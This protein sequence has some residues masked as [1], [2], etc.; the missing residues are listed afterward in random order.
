ML[1]QDRPQ[2]CHASLYLIA[3]PAHINRHGVELKIGG[4]GSRGH[5]SPLGDDRVTNVVEMANLC[6]LENY[7]MLDLCTVSDNRTIPNDNVSS[8]IGSFS[9]LAVFA[10]PSR[11]LDHSSMLNDRA[12]SDYNVIVNVD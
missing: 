4:D 11:S 3:F 9:E 8:H 12:L 2:L 5:V 7:A 6:L 1:A 10:N